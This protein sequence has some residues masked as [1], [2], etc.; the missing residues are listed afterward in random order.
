ME[1]GTFAIFEQMLDF[2]KYFQLHDISKASKGVIMEE[3][4]KISILGVP[5]IL[6]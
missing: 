4:V 6:L 3:R 5:V 2:P 1:N